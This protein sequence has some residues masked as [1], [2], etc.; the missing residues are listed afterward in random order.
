VTQ[1]DKNFLAAIGAM[2]VFIVGVAAGCWALIV[3]F[4]EIW[5]AMHG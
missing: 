5:R 2:V 4:V 1:D 3:V